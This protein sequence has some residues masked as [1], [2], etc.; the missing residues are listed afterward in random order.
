M[1]MENS[2]QEPRLYSN[3]VVNAHLQLQDNHPPVHAGVHLNPNCDN[4]HNLTVETLHTALRLWVTGASENMV[5]VWPE[6]LEGQD[7][8]Q[9]KC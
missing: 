6:N 1:A 5:M 3:L 9:W 4:L 2:N 7:P 8:S